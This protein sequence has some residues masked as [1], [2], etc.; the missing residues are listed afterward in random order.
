MEAKLSK[1][2]PSQ[3]LFKLDVFKEMV[4]FENWL[5]NLVYPYKLPGLPA[6]LQNSGLTEPPYVSWNQM[7]RR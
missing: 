5:E 1:K 3:T 7:C 4:E 2:N 6:S